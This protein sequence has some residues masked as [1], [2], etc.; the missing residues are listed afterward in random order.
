MK[1]VTYV[2]TYIVKIVSKL[3]PLAKSIDRKTERNLPRFYSLI[4]PS[5]NWNANEKRKRV[6]L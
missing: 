3:K 6:N 1:K 2:V 4:F 5:I